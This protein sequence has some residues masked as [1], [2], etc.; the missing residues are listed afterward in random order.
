MNAQVNIGSDGGPKKGAVLDLSQSGQKL[1]LI[2]PNVLLSGTT[3]Y[4]PM[5]NAS[6]LRKEG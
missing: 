5:I 1:G 3:P 6:P 2:L 4:L